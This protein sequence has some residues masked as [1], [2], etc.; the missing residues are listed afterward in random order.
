M[1]G[2]IGI[3]K[4][5]RYETHAETMYQAQQQLHKQIQATTRYKVKGYDITIILSEIDGEQKTHSTT[6]I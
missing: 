2:Y 1:N 6:T 3:Y 5:K 4:G